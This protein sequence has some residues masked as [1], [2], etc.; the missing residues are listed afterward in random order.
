MQPG[1]TLGAHLRPGPLL[2][3]KEVERFFDNLDSKRARHTLEPED[4]SLGKKTEEAGFRVGSFGDSLNSSSNSSSGASSSDSLT[5]TSNGSLHSSETAGDSKRRESD[6]GDYCGDVSSYNADLTH[7]G[8]VLRSSS[9][10]PENIMYQSSLTLT[11]SS[12]GYA[13]DSVSNGYLH[14]G[15]N[16]VYVPSTRA[17]LPVQYMGTPTQ[18]M[19]TPTTSTLW[20][21]P[22]DHA[23]AYTTANPIHTSAAFPFSSTPGPVAGGRNDSAPGYGTPLGRHSSLGAYPTYMGADLSPWNTFNNMALQ[24]GFRPTTGPAA[25]QELKQAVS[26]KF[27]F[28]LNS[29]AEQ[30][31][32]MGTGAPRR[33]LG[34]L[35]QTKSDE[36]VT[37]RD[38]LAV[39]TTRVLPLAL[40]H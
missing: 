7:F 13:Q 31:V 26:G 4:D 24:Q 28:Q 12:G 40:L 20:T 11:P 21:A 2:A 18:N 15:A 1:L 25:Q 8:G 6:I 14:S 29:S 10:A 3:S 22:N 34:Q 19:T 36:N 17:M 37:I 9:D 38:L 27:P 33:S 5:N 39:S 23:T 32:A 30:V 16:P 35:T